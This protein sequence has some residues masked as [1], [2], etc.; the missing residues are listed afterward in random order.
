MRKLR[1]A[2]LS[3]PPKITQ[4]VGAELRTLPAVHTVTENRWKYF[5]AACLAQSLQHRRNLRKTGI[6]DDTP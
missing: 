2:P 6:A 3:N 1:S 4:V 5:T